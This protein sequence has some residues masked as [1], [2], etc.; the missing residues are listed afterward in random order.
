MIVTSSSNEKLDRAKAL[1]ADHLINYR[2]NAASEDEVLRLTD[3]VGVGADFAEDVVG[4][5]TLNGTLK[6]MRFDGRI[7][8]MGV[9]TGFE[10]EVDTG[11]IVEK[12]ITRQGSIVAL[13]NR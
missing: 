3:G 6:A 8:L 11:A 5:A 12:R 1:G 9:L 4:T 7:S 2:D 13:W 10:A